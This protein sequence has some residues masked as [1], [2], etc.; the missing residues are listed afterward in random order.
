MV[1]KYPGACLWYEML[2]RHFV[3]F[4]YQQKCFCP[5][6]IDKGQVSLPRVCFGAQKHL[7]FRPLQLAMSTSFQVPSNTWQAMPSL[8]FTFFT[9]RH[10]ICPLVKRWGRVGA[11]PTVNLWSFSQTMAKQTGLAP[12]PH[13]WK[14]WPHPDL[15]A[16]LPGDYNPV[17]WAKSWW[18]WRTAPLGTTRLW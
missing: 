15:W 4:W 16:L 14:S 3:S 18:F 8:F 17:F 13:P 11:L 6:Q 5:I 2:T 10:L 1:T 7:H 9:A 12:G